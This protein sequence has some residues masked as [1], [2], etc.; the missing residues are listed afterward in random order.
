MYSPPIGSPLSPYSVTNTSN[1][2][3]QNML[4]NTVY[5]ISLCACT[6]GGCGPN[7]VITVMT[8]P[9][10]DLYDHSIDVLI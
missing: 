2:L 6:A 3:L 8:P 5:T 1:L 10:E 9:G 7:V 4:N